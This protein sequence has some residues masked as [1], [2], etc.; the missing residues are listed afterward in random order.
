MTIV[1]DEHSHFVTYPADA[2]STGYE[3]GEDARRV[4]GEVLRRVLKEHTFSTPP[5]DADELRSF[6]T[7]RYGE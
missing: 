2:T 1:Y 3:P 7:D 5:M 6:F 4:Y